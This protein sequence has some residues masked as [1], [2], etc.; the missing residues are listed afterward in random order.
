MLPKAKIICIAFSTCYTHF[1]KRLEE[2]K[3]PQCLQRSEYNLLIEMGL[4]SCFVKQS[5]EDTGNL[6]RLVK[7]HKLISK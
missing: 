2:E 3:Y 4:K 5:Y 6:L 1:A 7:Q